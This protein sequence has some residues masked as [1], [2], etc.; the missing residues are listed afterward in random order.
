MLIEKFDKSQYSAT[1]MK[2]GVA[3]SFFR[4]TVIAL[5]YI[6]VCYVIN[7]I[8]RGMPVSMDYSEI[9]PGI[10]ERFPNSDSPGQF[11]ILGIA[12]L[13]LGILNV[14]LIIV[15]LA[16]FSERGVKSVKFSEKIDIYCAEI[17]KVWQYKTA[18]I[19]SFIAVGVIPFIISLVMNTTTF[20]LIG[21][22][23]IIAT[24]PYLYCYTIFAKEG[25]DAYY[26]DSAE[27]FG[28]IV[29]RPLNQ[30]DNHHYSNSKKH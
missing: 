5:P 14:V 23:A 26:Q 11:L 10:T 13:A 30:G 3:S 15:T 12:M 4:G 6:V 9:F 29:Y 18:Y 17:I 24:S 16:I 2:I 8:L 25:K 7:F 27:Y 22:V 21:L 20:F 28:G 19:V 1:E